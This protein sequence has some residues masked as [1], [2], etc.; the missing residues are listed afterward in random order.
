MTKTNPE[1]QME[2]HLL[3]RLR[4]ERGA[5]MT[6]FVITLPI[7]I[8][9]FAGMG[10]LYRYSNEGLVA[11]MQTNQMLVDNATAPNTIPGFVPLAGGTMSIQSFGDVVINGSGALGMYFDSYVKTSLIDFIIPGNPIP[12]PA[13]PPQNNI[14]DITLMSGLNAP[15]SFSNMLLNDMA[16]P[17][18]DTSGWANIL[19]SI[20]QTFGVAPSLVAGI[21]YLPIQAQAPHTFSHP[22]TGSMT[23]DPGMLQLAS[24]TAAHH[25]VG[26]VAASRIAMNTIE[27]YKAC[28][29]EFNTALCT[30]GNPGGSTGSSPSTNPTAQVGQDAQACADQ[31]AIWQSCINS[32]GDPND[33]SVN[34]VAFCDCNCV[35]E[36]QRPPDSCA[37]VGGSMGPG[38][39]P[40][41]WGS[42]V[43]TP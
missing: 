1:P 12:A 42:G 14:E 17:N 26:A 2:R 13:S 41:G 34:P 35:C 32:C 28:I 43:A 10:M 21:R 4:N 18:W 3:S 23:Y 36:G 33:T 9:I 5:A 24:P 40:G 30:G 25:R 6:E 37:D 29:L 15:Q 8:M 38:S 16:S 27:P 11:R 31:S 20:V 39:L 22:W 7:F 19:A